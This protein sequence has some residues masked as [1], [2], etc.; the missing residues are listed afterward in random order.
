MSAP[1]NTLI[2]KWESNTN[3]LIREIV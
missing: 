3:E 1:P 2:L